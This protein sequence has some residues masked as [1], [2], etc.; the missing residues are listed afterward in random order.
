MRKLLLVLATALGCSLQLFAEDFPYGNY[1]LEELQMKAYAK[2]P[3]ANAVVLRE[4][5]KTWMSSND[6]LK[7]IHEYHVK[8]KIFNSK[9]F[10]EGDIQI[11][12]YKW[13]NN[14]F[15]TVSDLEGITYYTDEQG[16]L[17]RSVLDPQK[18]IRENTNRYWDQVKI[19]MPNLRPGCVIEYKYTITSPSPLKFKDWN[20]QSNIPKIYSEY[21]ARIPAYFN[22]KASLRGPYKLSK[23]EGV[24][25]RDC[26][27]VRGSK[28]DCSK[29]VYAMTDLPAF[30]KED[31]M[32]A[33]KNFMSALNFELNDYI[34]PYDGTKHPQ[35]QTW[36]DVDRILKQN[37]DFGS[38]LKK[39]SLF[40]DRLPVMTAGKTDPLEKAKAIY[41]YLQKNLKCND[42]MGFGADNGIRKTLDTHSGSVA[43]INLALVTALNAAG[44]NAEAVLLSTRAHGQ[45]NKL[46]PVVSDFNYVIAKVNIGDQSYL[47]DATEPLLPF[48][49]LP[50]HC[51]NDQ[52]RVMSLNKPSYWIDLVASQKRGRT[53]LLN[54]TLQPTGK[55]TGT[56]TN[57]ST[58]YEAWDKR[59]AIKKFNSVD[60]YVE[61]LDEKM[62]KI[63]ILKSNITNVD[64]LDL[65]LS[66]V[67]DVEI[68]AYDNLDNK[69]FAFNPFIT[70]KLTENPFKLEERT[71][72]VD[73]GAALNDRV[74]LV[75]QLPAEY[76][77]ET[78]P[79]KAG[80]GLP[81]N[82]GNFLTDYNLENN[83]LSFSHSI[84]LNQSVYS[85]AEYPYLKELFNKII[86]T[87]KS[88]I[89]ISRK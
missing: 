16:Q 69:R 60:E 71:Y 78:P 40:K 18:V 32:T 51:I 45:I 23:N 73:W 2:D 76:T 44:I 49:L 33:P 79:Q 21:E 68:N 85:P 67:Y 62:S 86:Q 34:N 59:R 89:I 77:V 58:G 42:L 1:K 56:I 64:S 6:G 31:Y 57:Y 17:Q 15:Q 39:T 82:G 81:N 27:E 22:F 53:Y 26:F 25:D 48:G 70:N 54:L 29:L 75:L 24:V 3:T 5:G 28:C 84:Q 14:T 87:E 88:D 43:D 55:L 7:L 52:G 10:D 19:A 80:V 37:E 65:P 47:L 46:Y 38:Q 72:P 9:A 30:V 8:V 41:A 12:L 61:D 11:P 50:M 13:D 36:A 83:K 66:E 20:F 4:F 63:K 74:V 35:T